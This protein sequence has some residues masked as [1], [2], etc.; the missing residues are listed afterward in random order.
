MKSINRDYNKCSLEHPAANHSGLKSHL[1]STFD[2][3]SK[4]HFPFHFVYW[5]HLHFVPLQAICLDPFTGS[6]QNGGHLQRWLRSVQARKGRERWIYVGDLIELRTIWG[7]HPQILI[8]RHWFEAVNVDKKA[9]HI[10]FCDCIPLKYIW[11][12]VFYRMVIF[13]GGNRNEILPDALSQ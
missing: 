5:T 3:Y 13:V 8:K 7:E 6:K 9:V 11:P 1:Y 4:L 2:L 10:R 12:F